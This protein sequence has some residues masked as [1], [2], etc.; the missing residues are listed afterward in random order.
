MC[1]IVSTIT[2][3]PGY[4]FTIN[5]HGTSAKGGADL[6]GNATMRLRSTYAFAESYDKQVRKLQFGLEFLA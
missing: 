2:I 6:P 5:A 1:D 3:D 4:K